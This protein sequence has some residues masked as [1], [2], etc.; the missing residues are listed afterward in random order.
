MWFN[1]CKDWSMCCTTDQYLTSKCNI[2]L[3]GQ[4]GFSLASSIANGTLSYSAL[5]TGELC[6][7]ASLLTHSLI[8]LLTYLLTYFKMPHSVPHQ[9][10]YSTQFMWDWNLNLDILHWV[11]WSSKSRVS[12]SFSF[13][14]ILASCRSA[15]QL[16]LLRRRQLGGAVHGPLREAICYFHSDFI[17]HNVQHC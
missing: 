4:V 2:R 17:N 10:W 1:Q 3:I 15:L 14:V 9:Y 6:A 12:T 5:L 16:R 7:Y 13:N 8:Y 11:T